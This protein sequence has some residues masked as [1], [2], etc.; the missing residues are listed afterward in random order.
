MK[1]GILPINKPKGI[2]SFDVIRRIKKILPVSAKKDK[3]GHGGTLDNLA[4]GVLPILFNEA[5]KAFDFL[6][7]SD[8]EYLAGIQLGAFTETD[9]SDGEV[10]EK[11]DRKVYLDEIESLLP[12][13][14]GK[15][16]QV[17]P[18]YSALRI[19]GKRSYELARENLEVSHKPRT[20][21]I[22]NIKLE[23]FDPGSR[24]LILTVTCSSG[25]YIR[26]LARDIG[27]KLRCGGYISSL[28][29]LKSAGITID[30]CKMIEEI[31]PE[32]FHNSLI[33]INRAVHLPLLELKYEKDYIYQ[34]KTLKDA[35]FFTQPLQNGQYKI[36][37]DNNLLAVLE[38]N[39]NYYKY[40]RVF[41][42]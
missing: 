27:M 42:E 12:E 23:S 11:F 9:D 10:I 1:S 20:I 31:T 38:K 40:L 29:R 26:S 5:T 30:E 21:E 25:T 35:A 32:N 36:V 16:S 24:Y 33:S 8:K 17:P 3:I 37:K 15:I 7:N 39:G 13:F 2:S 41:C 4:S 14:T 18:K 6:L 22:F 19:N 34:G 28:T